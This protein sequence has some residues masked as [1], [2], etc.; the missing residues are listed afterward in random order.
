MK[1]FNAI[2]KVTVYYEIK[3]KQSHLIVL[4]RR[5]GIEKRFLRG[6]ENLHVFMYF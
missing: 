2:D 5:K 1:V 4:G 6:C 3:K